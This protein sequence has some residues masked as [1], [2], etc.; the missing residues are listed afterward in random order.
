MAT[1]VGRGRRV[2]QGP[3]FVRLLVRGGE[4]L[5]RSADGGAQLAELGRLRA[6]FCLKRTDAPCLARRRRRRRRWCPQASQASC[7][8]TRSETGALGGAPEW[9]QGCTAEPQSHQSHPKHG[10]PLSSGL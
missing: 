1:G 6:H 3:G 2:G 5:L 4:R 9:L 10:G 7:T 8:Y